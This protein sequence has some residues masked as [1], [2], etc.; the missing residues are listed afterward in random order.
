MSNAGLRR[1][2]A[3]KTDEVCLHLSTVWYVLHVVQCH[4]Y[5]SHRNI[6]YYLSISLL[7]VYYRQVMIAPAIDAWGRHRFG[8]AVHFVCTFACLG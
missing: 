2:K 4:W 5:H 1:S 6:S 7:C 8:I 3:E